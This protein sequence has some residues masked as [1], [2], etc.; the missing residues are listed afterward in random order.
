MTDKAI[1]PSITPMGE[2]ALIVGFGNRVSVDLRNRVYGLCNALKERQISGITDIIPAYASLVIS[3]KPLGDTRERLLEQLP[4]MLNGDDATPPVGSH[5][6]VPVKYGGQDGADLVALAAHHSLT[7]DEA[8]RLHT[9]RD[10]SVYFLGFLPG[11][12]Y[13]GRVT[14]KIAT[15]RLSTPRVRVPAGSVGIA[16][17][18]TS[19]Y[20]FD[21]PG[22]WQI[23]GRAG[24]RVWDPYR[25]KPALFSYGDTVRYVSSGAVMDEAGAH[26]PQ[27]ESPQPLLRVIDPG[28]MTTI[29]DLGRLGVAN[30]GLSRGGVCDPQAA[31]RSNALVGNRP[32]AAVLEMTMTG[33]TLKAMAACTVALDGADFGCRVDGQIVP[34]GVGWYVRAG[35]TLNFVQMSPSSSGA[36]AFMAV[37]GGF[38]A[39]EVLGSRS[40][41]LPAGFGGYGGRALKAG[42]ILG[43]VVPPATPAYIAGR[44]WM[45]RPEQALRGRATLRFVRYSGVASAGISVIRQLMRHVWRVTQQSDRIGLRFES[46]V[47]G[48]ISFHSREATSF[49]VVRGA[50]Q[51]TPA[52]MPVVLN[53][54]HQ[55]TGGYPLAGVVA[56]ID[57]PVLTQLRPGDAVTFSEISLDDALSLLSASRN[58]LLAGLKKL[59]LGDREGDYALV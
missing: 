27:F 47:G 37:A 36:R 22:G 49:G 5:H 29:Q 38:D 12:A 33:P 45:S 32:N 13:M 15:P 35:A 19:I 56:Q 7:A 30:L 51:I 41:C 17:V 18:Q 16:G 39:P 40:T 10:Y 59:G 54:D 48:G 57:Y 8:V 44:Y 58:T 6:V 31:M 21:S 2:S 55:T 9:N 25:K 34:P 53:A 26:V 28:V 52:G 46:E 11:F 50:I 24:I 4:E 3:F 42:D 43:G 14:P 20:P 23:V 1:F